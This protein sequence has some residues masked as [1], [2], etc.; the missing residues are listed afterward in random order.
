MRYLL[1]TFLLLSIPAT[2]HETLEIFVNERYINVLLT[3]KDNS[4]GVKYM[5]F[6]NDSINWSVKE[7]YKNQ[8]KYVS[9]APGNGTKTIYVKFQD[10]AGN[11]SKEPESISFIWISC[12]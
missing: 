10:S 2:A 1:L 3:S 11:W 4:S 6:S 9:V 8:K 5:K 7:E 12:Y